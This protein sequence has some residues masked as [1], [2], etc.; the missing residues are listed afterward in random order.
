[1]EGRIERSCLPQEGM[2]PSDRF[3]KPYALWLMKRGQGDERFYSIQ[4]LRCDLRGARKIL[5]SV[6]HP[7]SH[8]NEAAANSLAQDA[9]GLYDHTI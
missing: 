9:K 8:G 2:H 1:M 6:D 4:N 7:V 3:D 5:T